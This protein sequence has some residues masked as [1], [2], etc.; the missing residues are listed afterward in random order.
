MLQYMPEAFVK[1]T[2]KK[3]A[4]LHWCSACRTLNVEMCLR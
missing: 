2:I 3:A 4:I 1:R